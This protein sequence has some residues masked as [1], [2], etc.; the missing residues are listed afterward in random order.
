M[1]VHL[2]GASTRIILTWPIL[3]FHQGQFHAGRL[4]RL[5]SLNNTANN[6]NNSNTNNN[7]TSQQRQNQ[8]KYNYLK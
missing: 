2:C 5:H 4:N 7:A 6:N 8:N 1:N 3:I